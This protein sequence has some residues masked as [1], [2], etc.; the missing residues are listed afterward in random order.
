MTA[1]YSPA[2]LRDR[3]PACASRLAVTPTGWRRAGSEV[4][5][6]YRCLNVRCRNEWS[7]AW[8]LSVL[9]EAAA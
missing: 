5:C 4:V 6:E 9:G 2:L 1:A 8:R 7:V 3:C